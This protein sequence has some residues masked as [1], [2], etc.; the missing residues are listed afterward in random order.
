MAVETIIK[1][2]KKVS[3]KEKTL[4]E[5]ERQTIVHVVMKEG[6]YARVWPSTYLIER[7]TD[8]RLKLVRS[9]N[10]AIYPQWGTL[11]E[12]GKFTLIFKGLS[13]SCKT[14]DL[15]EL[16]PQPGAFYVDNIVR[17]NTDVYEV[18]I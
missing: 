15:A 12:G 13:K 9:F 14:F 7:E 5:S 16:I 2:K 8:K 17:N 1:T 6:C 11:K 4:T 3:K 18:A 10:I